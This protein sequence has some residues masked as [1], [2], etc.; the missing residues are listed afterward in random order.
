M[1]YSDIELAITLIQAAIHDTYHRKLLLFLSDYGFALVF[2]GALFEG[3]TIII[4]AGILSHQ[5]VLPFTWTV[6]AAAVGAFSGDQ[7]SF[8]IGRRYGSKVLIRFPRVEQLAASVRL[9]LT[10]SADLV[11]FGCRFVYGT[12]IVVPML[13]G[14]NGYSPKRFA[15]IN[16]FSAVLWAIT[17]VSAGYLVGSGAEKLLGRIE[18]LEQLLLAVLL[19]MLGWW[20]H[21][22]RKFRKQTAGKSTNQG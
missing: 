20:W 5:S 6:C 8:Y 19:A 2:F 11:A 15:L 22:H 10:A 13:L 14:A 9:Q 21:R 7:I 4:L 12:R 17:G 3:E 1:V 18:H 16:L